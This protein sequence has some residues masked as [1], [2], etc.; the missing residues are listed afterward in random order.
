[1]FERDV[2][3]PVAGD[4]HVSTLDAPLVLGDYLEG[5]KQWR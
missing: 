3:P 5:W 4:G 2:R 1:V